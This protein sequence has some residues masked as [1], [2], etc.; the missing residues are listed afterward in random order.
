MENPIFPRANIKPK[1]HYARNRTNDHKY[2]YIRFGKKDSNPGPWITSEERRNE[3][4]KIGGGNVK[5]HTTCTLIV[6]L[7]EKKKDMSL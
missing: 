4:N 1:L 2:K 6:L 3:A 5:L 7:K